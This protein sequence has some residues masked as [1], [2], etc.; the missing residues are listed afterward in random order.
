[1][2][3]CDYKEFKKFHKNLKI[4]IIKNRKDDIIYVIT[5]SMWRAQCYV[6]SLV[7]LSGKSQ[8]IMSLLL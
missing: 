5:G 4:M 7:L 3:D 8:A 2:V 6:Y 1:M